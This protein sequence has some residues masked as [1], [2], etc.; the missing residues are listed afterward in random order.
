MHLYVIDAD[1][2]GEARAL[3]SGEWEI[4]D[5]PPSSTDRRTFY[6]TTSEVHPGERHLYAIPGGRHAHTAHRR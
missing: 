1:A 5:V 4:S 3:T 2:G 6:I